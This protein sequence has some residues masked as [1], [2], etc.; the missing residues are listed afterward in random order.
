MDRRL[1]VLFTLGVLILAGMTSAQSATVT[2]VITI[3]TNLICRLI[4][5]L[6]GIAAAVASIVIVIAGIRWVGSAEDA[7]ARAAAKS[8]MIHAII[9]LIIVIVALAIVNWAVT[10]TSVSRTFTFSCG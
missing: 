3:I 2:S 8:T 9:G 1:I 5:V 4:L 6:Y 10:G 7:G